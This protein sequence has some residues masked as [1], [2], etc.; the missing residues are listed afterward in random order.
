MAIPYPEVRRVEPEEVKRR[1]EAGDEIV[2]VD[3][4]PAE[5]YAAGHIAG[6]RSLP[7]GMTQAGMPTLP[8]DREIVFY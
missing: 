7:R 8:R 2:L 6:A 3:V 1:L 4:R 5:A